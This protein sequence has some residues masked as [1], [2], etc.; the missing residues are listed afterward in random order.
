MAADT[1]RRLFFTPSVAVARLGG[2]LTPLDAFEWVAGDPHTVAETRVRPTWTLDVM[3]DATVLPR[4]PRE[5]VLRDGPLLRPV[6]P[7]LELWALTGDGPAPGWQPRPVSPELLAAN[8]VSVADLTF[9]VTARNLKAARRTGNPAVGFGTFPAVQVRGDDHRSTP[10]LGTS[11]PGAGPAMIPPGRSIPLGQLQVLRPAV[12][13]A[14]QPWSDVLRL[15]TIRVRFTPARGRFYGPPAAA[16]VTPPA[17]VPERAFLDPDAG[18]LGARQGNR[19]VPADTVDV[20]VDAQGDQTSLGVVDDTCD[21]RVTVEL[22]LAGILL[23]GRANIAV[24]P[25][26][27]APDRR[28]FLSVADELNDRQDDPTRNAAMSQAERDQWVADLFERIFE[29][30]A[31]MDVDLWRA[32]FARTL[33]AGEQRSPIPG[34]GV[35]QPTRAMGGADAL[36]DPNIAIPAPSRIDPLPLTERARERHRN[37][38]DISELAPWVLVNPGRLAALIRP[39]LSGSAAEF[40]AQRMQMPPFMRHSNAGALSLARW[41][42]DLL[43]AWAEALPG[44]LGAQPGAALPPLS[45]A[46]QERRRQVLSVLDEEP[47]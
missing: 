32:S 7:F 13:P 46:A 33:T 36:R 2:S 40:G 18:W 35:P 45:P 34:D 16:Q 21:A 19:V 20:Q 28:P 27:Y 26:H 9:T 30:V 41:Q 11:P 25:P 12:H 6:A 10:L 31:A 44:V 29:T 4:L 43:M 38:S 5:L 24:A 23:R 3:P 39:P 14:G 42:Y 37:L 1:I 22:A 47:G 17:V 8:G 15:D